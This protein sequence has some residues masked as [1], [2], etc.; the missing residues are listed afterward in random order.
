M[1]H[2]GFKS[3]LCSLS[4]FILGSQALM[5][6]PDKAPVIVAVIES[7]SPPQLTIAGSNFGSVPPTATLNG[8]PVTVMSYTDTLVVVTLPPTSGPQL[9]IGFSSGEL[10]FPRRSAPGKPDWRAVPD[11]HA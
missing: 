7:Q 9:R 1:A 2:F 4:V 6:D 11:D 10:K 5:A 8:V 3:L